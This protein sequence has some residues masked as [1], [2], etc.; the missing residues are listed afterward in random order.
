[1]EEHP[2][3]GSAAGSGGDEPFEIFSEA[4][5]LLGQA[6][7]RQVHAN[8]YWHKSAHV[9]LYR[10]DGALYLQRRAAD[11]DVC[12]DLWD[13]SAAEHLR[14]GESYHQA[15]LRGLSEELGISGAAL[16][17]L[18]E[19]FKSRLEQPALGIRDYE[20]QQ[21]FQGAWDG[22]LHPDPAEV[23][24]VRAVTL[25]A[26]AREVREAPHAFT[27]WLRRDLTRCGILNG[28]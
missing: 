2:A 9:F 6:P 12:P 27:P 18:G 19:L 4:G 20:F 15:A 21:A 5:E 10:P 3:D 26:L 14:P 7:R 1:M 23:A 17:P 22:P 11:K 13:Q 8:G 24:E 25:P 28:H 16:E